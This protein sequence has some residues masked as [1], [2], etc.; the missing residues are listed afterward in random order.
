[1]TGES[2]TSIFDVAKYIFELQ[3]SEPIDQVSLHKLLWFCQGWHYH[4]TDEPLFNE[5]FVARK[6]GPV[7][8]AIWESLKGKRIVVENEIE[9]KGNSDN[10]DDFSKGVIEKVVN[11]YS[12]FDSIALSELAYQCDPWKN[13]VNN[14][15]NEIDNEEI[16]VFFN[17]ES[18][19]S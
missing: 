8:M 3:D 17:D 1:M 13:N 18:I 4:V 2:D 7:P 6:Y 15:K 12:Q 16:R 14:E 10:I 5:A 9:S 19:M 11:Y